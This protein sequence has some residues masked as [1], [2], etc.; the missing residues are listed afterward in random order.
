MLIRDAFRALAA[1]LAATTMMLTATSAYGQSQDAP[2]ESD[3]AAIIADNAA[4]REQLRKLGR[5]A[6]DAH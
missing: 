3:I 4:L 5:A 2:R 6:E 1:A